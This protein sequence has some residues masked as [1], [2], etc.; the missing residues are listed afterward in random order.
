MRGA[1]FES[2]VVAELLK[3]RFGRG[4]GS[5]LFFWRDRSGH[6]VDVLVE[7]GAALVPVETKSGRT[8]ARDFFGGIEDWRRISGQSESEAWLVFGGEREQTHGRVRV[9]PWLR[10][11][12]LTARV[13]SSQ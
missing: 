11:R 9:L 13:V 8:V 5:N 7:L 6:E 12:E 1:L 3:E 2:W 10:I 4:L